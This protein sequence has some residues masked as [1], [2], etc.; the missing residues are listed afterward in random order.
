MA[1]PKIKIRVS[2][3]FLNYSKTQ[4]D[5]SNKVRRSKLALS[6]VAGIQLLYDSII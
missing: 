3:S 6:V 1:P 4:N 2:F 5:I